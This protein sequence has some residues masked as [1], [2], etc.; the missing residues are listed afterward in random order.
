MC[1]TEK[2]LTHPQP[3]LLFKDSNQECAKMK[4]ITLPSGLVH[5]LAYNG[6]AA[7]GQFLIWLV[8]LV[9]FQS[10]ATMPSIVPKPVSVVDG[11]G[12]FLLTADSAIDAD[13][14]SQQTA[15][16]LKQSLAPA[17]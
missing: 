12:T 7:A 10:R 11:W 15:R 1:G 14:E 4:P 3:V 16:R 5:R 2:N 13:T 17:T 9:A 6:N 8:V